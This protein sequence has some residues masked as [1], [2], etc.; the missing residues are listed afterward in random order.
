MKTTRK[1]PIWRDQEFPPNCRSTEDVYQ[2]LRRTGGTNPYGENNYLAVLAHE[3]RF[4]SGAAFHDY[5]PGNVGL[6][7]NRLE[8]DDEI[9][10]VPVSL[11]Q[12]GTSHKTTINVPVPAGMHVTNPAYRIVKEMRWVKRWP[13][14]KGWAILHWEAGAG[15]C[16]R[17]WW[18]DK[19]VPGTD[20]RVLGPWP[21]R[22][23]YWTFC[24]GIDPTATSP[25]KVVTYATFPEIPSRT[26]MERA[27]AQFEYHKSQ[28]DNIA[29]PTFRQLAALSEAHARDEAQE[30]KE[31]DE[32]AREYRDDISFVLSSSL[33]AGRV[34]EGIAKTLRSQGIEVGHV[35]N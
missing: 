35:G 20:L 30:K 7:R 14:L 17:S 11:K 12:E 32:L 33:E 13:R 26:W 24:E 21:E 27:I 19:L 23:M 1:R 6:D 29:D 25:D 3:V 5:A 28:P 22:G 15:G 16:S 4:L 31:R 8:F 2:F 18:E 34:R 9:K 10:I